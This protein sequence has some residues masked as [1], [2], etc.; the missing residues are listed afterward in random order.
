MTSPQPVVSIPDERAGLAKACRCG[1]TY[2]SCDALFR[3]SEG[4]MA[5]MAVSRDT[6]G[7]GGER[8]RNGTEKGTF[9]AKF[10]S[11]RLPRHP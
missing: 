4:G 1:R 10:Q 7:E 3:T 2:S 9:Y 6:P 5:R 8:G 11:G